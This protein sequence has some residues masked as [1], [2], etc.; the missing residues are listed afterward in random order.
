M[1]HYAT[2]NLL[3]VITCGLWPSPLYNLANPLLISWFPHYPQ[4]PWSGYII[5]LQ[6]PELYLIF[7]MQWKSFPCRQCDLSCPVYSK[8]SVCCLLIYVFYFGYH[9]SVAG[10]LF[11]R[12]LAFLLAN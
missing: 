10:L 2:P 12:Y 6:F 9:S 8:R 4:D 11:W 3:R 7:K 5:L 1:A